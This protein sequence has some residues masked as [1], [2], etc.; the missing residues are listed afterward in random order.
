M[1]VTVLADHVTRRVSIAILSVIVS[2]LIEK[3]LE[4]LSIATD[5]C[6]VQRCAQILGLAVQAGSKLRENLNH[7]HMAF[8]ARNMERGP[9][10]GVTLVE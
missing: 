10:I 7:L 9:S 5:A 8:I 6:N 3:S 1:S 2:L 4:N